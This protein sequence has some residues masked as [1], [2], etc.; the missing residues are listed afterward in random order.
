MGRKPFEV[1]RRGRPACRRTRDHGRV[2]VACR[3]GR[4]KLVHRYRRPFFSNAPERNDNGFGIAE[5]AAN[6]IPGNKARETIQVTESG[7]IGH[8]AIVTDFRSEEKAKT[9]TKEEEFAA[10]QSKITH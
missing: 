7:E 2:E 6:V 3:S 10:C 5:N 4:G 9:A 1:G 8:A